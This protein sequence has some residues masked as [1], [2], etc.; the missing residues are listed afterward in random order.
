MDWNRLTS[1]RIRQA[2]AKGSG[3]DCDD[4]CRRG[5]PQ[6]GVLAPLI[7][8]EDAWHLLFI[9]R[10]RFDR[11]RHS[12][13]VAFAGGK[14]E[15]GDA[16]IRVTALREAEE[17]LGIERESLQLLGRLP[18]YHSGTGYCIT[19]QVAL[20]DWP[21]SLRPEPREVARVFSLPL[22]W[23]ADPRNWCRDRIRRD[24]GQAVEVIRYDECDGECL[25]GATAGMVQSLLRVLETGDVTSD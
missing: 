23:L 18:S 20:L 22:H 7:R 6:A 11:D 9:R 1:D 21:C 14:R 8:V 25:W 13:Q 4:R 19:P 16:D 3:D 10:T 17:E 15:P 12:G 5:L 24:N 2:L